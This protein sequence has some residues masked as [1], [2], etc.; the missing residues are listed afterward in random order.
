MIAVVGAGMA[1]LVAAARLREL[2]RDIAVH[3]KGTRLGGSMLVS[4]CVLWRHREWDDFC[5]ECPAGDERLQRLLWER[6]DES[7]EWLMSRGAVPVWDETGNPGTVG[8]RFDPKGL[9]EALPDHTLQGRFAGGTLAPH[10]VPIAV[11]PDHAARQP[12]RA[13]R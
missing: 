6:F 12:H 11:A 10:L 9:V 2:G 13:A 5:S 1:G 8:K 7:V 3:E 4:S